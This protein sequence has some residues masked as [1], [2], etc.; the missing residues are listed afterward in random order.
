MIAPIL[1]AGII[2]ILGISP[3]LLFSSF[4][5]F[6]IGKEYIFIFILFVSFLKIWAMKRWNQNNIWKSLGFTS[7]R[8]S[9]F[10]QSFKRELFKSF[11]IILFWILLLIFGQFL[12]FK[13]SMNFS[14]L[15]DILF[16]SIFVG[17]AEE[18]L[19]RV[20]FFEEIKLSLGVNKAILLQSII[21][22]VA[23]PY[24]VGE[25]LIVNILMKIGLLMLGIYLNL[26][27]INNYP[28]IFP[29]IAF[30]GG[31]VGYI[32]LA[33]SFFH[34]QRNYP[35]LIY[36]IQNE[37]FINP[38]SGLIGIFTLSILNIYQIKTL[39]KSSRFV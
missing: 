14:L 12:R 22:S 21:F 7:F 13:S 8:N 29:S 31:I 36:G 4:L 11:F 19:F 2:Y 9:L 38:I 23:H 25:N 5:P 35:F 26:L 6:L 15:F 16:T 37:N 30:H 34:V 1:F 39:K 20:W 28:N 18:L 27:R 17:V 33:K 10:N 32:F 3:V 24:I